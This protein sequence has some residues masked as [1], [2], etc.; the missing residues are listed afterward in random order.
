MTYTQSYTQ[1][2]QPKPNALLWIARIL[3][4]L[5]FIFS[6]LIKANDPMGFGY[7]L[8]EYFH[9]L[10]LGILNDYDNWIA[11]FLCALEIIL[12]ALLILGIA[13]K[14]VAWGLLILIVFFYLSHILF[15]I[16]RGR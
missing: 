14:K 13:G 8:Q 1:T 12:G 10:N 11:I 5:L 15:S 9:V 2:Q 4:G 7:K 3:V 6:G 16:L